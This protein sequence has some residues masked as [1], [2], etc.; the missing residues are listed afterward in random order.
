MKGALEAAKSAVGVQATVG[1]YGSEDSTDDACGLIGFPT[2]NRLVGTLAQSFC[3]QERGKVDWWLAR[4][5][6][7]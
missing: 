1:T 2:L 6:S 7:R 3:V 5:L 4:A